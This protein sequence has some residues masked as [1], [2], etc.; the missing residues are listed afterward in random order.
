VLEVQQGRVFERGVIGR[1]EV[2]GEVR[3]EPETE[4]DRRPGQNPGAGEPGEPHGEEGRDA[5]H[6]ERRRPLREDDV[7]EQMRPEQV[8]GQRVERGDRRDDQQQAAGGE[9]CNAP[10]RGATPADKEGVPAGQ[11][12]DR[13]RRLE[14]KRPGVWVRAS[15]RATLVLASRP[16]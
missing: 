12:D 15:D 4:R 9:S 2:P 13:E 3:D 6:Q 1:G 10:A 14:V 16:W 11:R 7:L 5:E 8:V